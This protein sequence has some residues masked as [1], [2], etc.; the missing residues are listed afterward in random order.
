MFYTYDR[1]RRKKGE[2]TICCEKHITSETFK[3]KKKG[4]KGQL[5]KSLLEK[6]FKAY[7]SQLKKLQPFFQY[8]RGKER[9][10][11]Q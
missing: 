9:R 6:T 3:D 11:K 4:G 2:K 1:G 10:G 7:F 5:N 8:K